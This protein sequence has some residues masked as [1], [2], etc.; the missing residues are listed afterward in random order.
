[1]NLGNPVEL[2]DLDETLFASGE[3][4]NNVVC[5]GRFRST[6][7]L[8]NST[9]PSPPQHPPILLRDKKS[10]ILGALRIDGLKS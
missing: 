9:P 8:K 4:L 2:F 7:R 10:L 1:M 6:A 3:S 5:K